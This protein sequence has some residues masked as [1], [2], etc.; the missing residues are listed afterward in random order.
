V[1]IG[2]KLDLVKP[3]SKTIRS[4]ELNEMLI[5]LDAADNF[6]T[7]AKT[8]EGIEE[9]FKCLA[10]KIYNSNIKPFGK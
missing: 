7:S 8:G 9:A 6:K 10:L 1:L 5:D 4:K 2:N 3:K